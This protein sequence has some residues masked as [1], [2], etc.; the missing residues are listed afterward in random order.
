MT[1]R[2]ARSPIPRADGGDLL[3]AHG[4]ISARI[5]VQ[6]AAELVEI[7]MSGQQIPAA[8]IDDGAVPGLAVIITKGFDHT[9]VFAF[10]ALAD[11]GPDQAQEHGPIAAIRGADMSLQLYE[12]VC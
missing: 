12:I 7:K 5:A 1:G 4:V 9:H 2:Q 3:A 10:D 8:E 11:G 6:Q